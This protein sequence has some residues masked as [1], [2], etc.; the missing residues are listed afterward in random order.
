MSRG[1]LRRHRTGLYWRPLQESIQRKSAL[2][3][4]RSWKPSTSMSAYPMCPGPSLG[5]TWIFE[6]L[7]GAQ[8]LV[9]RPRCAKQIIKRQIADHLIGHA[10]AYLAVGFELLIVEELVRGRLIGEIGVGALVALRRHRQLLDHG[11]LQIDDGS[12]LGPWPA[13]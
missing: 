2:G 4:E 6:T 9:G 5:G 1:A 3:H 11:R 7:I 10:I 12:L 8:R 13:A